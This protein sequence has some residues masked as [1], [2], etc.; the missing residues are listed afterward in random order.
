MPATSQ[1]PGG[2]RTEQFV[3]SL[4]GILPYVYEQAWQSVR[5][6]S[7]ALRGALA[8]ARFPLQAVDWRATHP[9]VQDARLAERLAAEAATGL[10]REEGPPMRATLIRRTDR[11]WTFAWRYA[12]G[13][14]DR[15]AG[16]RLLSETAEEYGVLLR[17]GPSRHPEPSPPR[18][19]AP[20]PPRSGAGAPALPALLGGPV[21]DR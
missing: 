3:L 21:G 18:P 13:L 2:C 19:G 14:L 15:G 11:T 8:E 17:G 20:R 5:A 16:A 12:R 4:T 7:P 10:A 9:A 1:Q 6:A